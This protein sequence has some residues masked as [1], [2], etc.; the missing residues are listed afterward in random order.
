[1][2]K[3]AAADEAFIFREFLSYAVFCSN[4]DIRVGRQSRDAER[5]GAFTGQKGHFM[6]TMFVAAA[7]A[8]ALTSAAI[9]A[10]VPIVRKAPVMAPVVSPF[11]IAFGGGIMS[12]YNFRGISQSDRGPAVTAYFEPRYNINPNLQLYAGVAGTSVKLATD[13]TAEIDFY[14]GI[15]PTFG[16][17]AFDFG[18]IYYWYPRERAIDGVVIA[19]PNLNTTIA[20]TDF[21]EIYGKAA[22]TVNDIVTLGGSL[23]YSPSWL[24]TGA[25]GTYGSVTAKFTAPGNMLPG[26]IGAYLSAEFGYYWLGTTDFVPGVFVDLTGTRGWDLP[27][28]SYWNAGIGFTYKAL[29]L[30]LRYH[31]T[32]LS[33]AECNALTADPGAAI[34]P[35]VAINNFATGA[36]SKWCDATFIAKLSFDLTLGGLK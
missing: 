35:A 29:T 36:A 12:D 11:D 23:Y 17:V 13:P 3:K 15:R 6:K 34:I 14:A 16:P 22:W 5:N 33:R 31:D 28:Y 1:L 20:D 8:F 32:D 21:W 24:N 7:S 25:D 10:D 27:D 9:A 4:G 19:V 18:F 30:D 2:P 26:G